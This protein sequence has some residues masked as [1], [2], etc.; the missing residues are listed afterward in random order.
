MN[1]HFIK[2][3]RVSASQA[4]SAGLTVGSGKGTVAPRTRDGKEYPG[5]RSLRRSLANL[6]RRRE[7]DQGP[8][9]HTPDSHRGSQSNWATEPGSMK[10]K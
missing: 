2:G 4:R 8:G 5:G 10:R 9:H 6:K 1:I 7:G 3:A